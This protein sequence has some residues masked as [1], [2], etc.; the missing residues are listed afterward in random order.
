MRNLLVGFPSLMGRLKQLREATARDVWREIDSTNDANSA[1][2][3]VL[4][5]VTN[6][7]K[8]NR[9]DC[10]RYALTAKMLSLYLT[11][12]T[13]FFQQL[14]AGEHGGIL[15]SRQEWQTLVTG[16]LMRHMGQLVCNGHAISDMEVLRP[17]DYGDSYIRDKESLLQRH[18]YLCLASTR[19]FTAIFPRISIL[20]HS[21]DPN[22]RNSFDGPYLTIYAARAIR[23]GEQVFNCY[24]PHYKLMDR[25]ER[26]SVLTQQYCFECD[27]EKCCSD[28]RTIDEYFRY[29]C[30][31]ANCGAPIDLRGSVRQRWWLELN[32]ERVCRAIASKFVCGKCHEKLFLNP[33]SLVTFASQ[34][35]QPSD[36]SRRVSSVTRDLLSYYFAVAK[37]LGKHH[38]LKQWMTEQIFSAKVDGKRCQHEQIAAI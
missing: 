8:M 22:I 11:E 10:L 37:C 26:Q 3:D 24:G 20:N 23:Q 9:L 31:N 14:I 5:L 35:L 28:D 4:S 38:E 21:C 1:Y 33:H 13:S 2:G 34:A 16:I 7:D 25:D 12:H 30:P 19:V 17:A 18:L 36:T 6:F 32:D 29:V 15:R 27:C